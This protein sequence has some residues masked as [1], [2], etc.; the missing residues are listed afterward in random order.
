M[1]VIATQVTLR[2]KLHKGIEFRNENLS[3]LN[4]NKTELIRELGNVTQDT[5][6]TVEYR[7]KRIKELLKIVDLDIENL[8]ALPFQA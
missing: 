1:N 7:L 6:I 8:V 3:D 5:E 4:N 2:V